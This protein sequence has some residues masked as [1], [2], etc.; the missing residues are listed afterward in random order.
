MKNPLVVI[1]AA[2]AFVLVMSGGAIALSPAMSLLASPP[3][4]SCA[5]TPTKIALPVETPA[6]SICVQNL[7]AV[8]VY[9]G[10]NNVTTSTGF[11]LPAGSTSA[12]TQFCFDAQTGW[13]IVASGTSPLRL[14]AGT[15]YSGR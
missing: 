5:T 4:V 1:L 9:V 14:L 12:P 6:R 13:C 3:T 11:L 10:G 15:G 7:D 8:D 2:V